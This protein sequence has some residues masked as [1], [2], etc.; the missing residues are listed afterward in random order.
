MASSEREKRAKLNEIARQQ[1]LEFQVKM[2]TNSGCSV[3]FGEVGECRVVK[4]RTL[5]FLTFSPSDVF[6]CF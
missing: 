5:L 6:L 2:K 1:A 3:T 4:M